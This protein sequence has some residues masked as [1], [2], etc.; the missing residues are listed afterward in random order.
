MIRFKKR[1]FISALILLF[2]FV[3]GSCLSDSE[4]ERENRIHHSPN[5]KEG[6]FVNPQP[7][8]NDIWQMLI[9]MFRQSDYV[10]PNSDLVIPKSDASLF[11]KKPPSGLRVTWFGHSSSLVEM[12]GYNL[13]IDP[14][15]SNRT[16]PISWIGPKRW[17]DPPL[18]LEELPRVDFVLISHNHYDHLDYD[19][20]I[21][22]GKKGVRFVVPL[23]VGSHLE[24]W[25]IP[26][27]NIIELDWWEN[28]KTNDFEIVCTPARHASGRTLTDKD[29]HLWAGYAVLGTKHRFYYSGDTGLFPAMKEIGSKYGPFDL[30]LIE[31]G[32]YHESWKDWHIGPEQAVIA[33]T[34]VNGKKMFPVHWGLFGLAYH[35]WTEPV[36]R[37]LEKAKE[38][39][40]KV[41]TP[42]PGQSI[43]PELNE[44]GTKWW[45]EVPWVRGKD[46]PIRSTQI[47]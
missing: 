5:W 38:M 2:L 42:R 28:F 37:V 29:E 47:D 21:A 46:N 20:V 6:S 34:W 26:N 24:D 7:L 39:N 18:S 30:T 4:T 25:G 33:H 1:I 10:T 17:Y 27:E 11:F 13:L 44:T 3:S 22:L 14:V 9:G 23:A 36:E 12:D 45:P 8:Q 31:V 40:V 15:W 35:G 32:Q 19:T 16:S 43:E 41:L